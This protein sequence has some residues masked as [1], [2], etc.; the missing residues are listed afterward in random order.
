MQVEREEEVK[1]LENVWKELGVKGGIA[2]M[3]GPNGV[4]KYQL[5]KSFS[6][7]HNIEFMHYRC[8]RSDLHIPLGSLRRFEG[9]Y[10]PH[11]LG[12]IK[13]NTP[14]EK[15]YDLL[16]N[17]LSGGSKI[18]Y[19]GRID[20]ADYLSLKFIT[21]F[22]LNAPKGIM[23]VVSYPTEVER[24]DLSSIL[25]QLIM[26][27]LA[28]VILVDSLSK[29]EIEK[30]V[31]GTPLKDK[32]AEIVEKSRGNPMYINFL[33]DYWK[34]TGKVKIFG[35]L[36]KA[37]IGNYK[38]LPQTER[39][40]LRTGAVMG[41]M[42]FKDVVEDIIGKDVSE[43]LKNLVKKRWISEFSQRYEKETHP[44]Y[45]FSHEMIRD[46]IEHLINEKNMKK[47]HEKIASSIEKHKL[48]FSWERVYEL[49]LH[50]S[51]ASDAKMAI[52]YLSKATELCHKGQDYHSAVYYLKKIEDFMKS[53]D[54]H[55]ERVK[56]YGD[57]SLS[58]RLSGN[59][60]E[61]VEYDDK[62]TYFASLQKADAL[63]RM[64]KFKDAL[65]IVKELHK[66]RDTYLR[67]LSY[68][69]EG[70][71]LRRMG[72]YQDALKSVKNHLKFAK[73][74]FNEREM[75]IAYKNIG[76]IYLSMMDVDR[77]EKYYGMAMKIF[78]KLKDPEGIGAIYNNMG[79]VYSQRGSPQKAKEFYFKGLKMDEK[80][81]DYEGMGTAY[82][83]I[84]TIYE[85]LGKYSDAIDSY[86]KSVK[87]NI[88]TGSL[89]GVEYAYS[90][91]SSLYTEMGKLRDAMEYAKKEI[92]IA[93]KTGSV[94]FLISGYMSTSN[95][96]FHTGKYKKSIE[97]AE[98]AW[99]IAKKHKNYFDAV[100][101]Y[102]Y[103][104]RSNYWL[105]KTD[106]CVKNAK[107]AL[108][109]YRKWNI[110]DRAS[111]IY[112]LLA[113][114]EGERVIKEMEKKVKIYSPMDECEILMAK[115]VVYAGKPEGKKYYKESVEKLKKLKKFATLTT[116]LKEY[117]T[118]AHDD[119][120]MK[121]AKEVEKDFEYL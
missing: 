75:A 107:I 31:E 116:F 69:V 14:P 110:E 78:R 11:L 113:R 64:G 61:S 15:V 86:E 60:E 24:E 103:I 104:A 105:K 34:E 117:G 10:F 88:L 99:D 3:L 98:K 38:I 52:K 111:H 71:T 12:K 65:A 53:L 84:G 93:R 115:A 85:E 100:D 95:I 40:I 22:A 62:L 20:Y 106:E 25:E 13:A 77:G 41:N 81:R 121:M 109:H 16:L 43:N 73:K 26:E 72:L 83:N 7:K 54:G 21:Y 9:I 89:D 36:T 79:I 91:L 102:Y 76:N 47:L 97:Y 120:A 67:M 27:D 30:M 118:I 5:L 1:K 56:L 48:Y 18:V 8:E 63:R 94:K 74:L 44:G 49:S 55:S 114:C 87:Y 108:N 28:T 90:N 68:K 59:L 58:L 29:E 2:I 119:T 4:G 66:I 80:R 23:F 96:Y 101:S 19:F 32:I 46:V 37:I 51:M 92:K 45:V 70:D 6:S 35:D 57:L 112:S 39:E 17:A 33:L 82:N 42:F 50:Y